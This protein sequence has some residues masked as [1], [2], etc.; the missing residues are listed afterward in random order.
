MRARLSAV[1]LA[2]G[3]TSALLLARCSI[4]SG[5]S[6]NCGMRVAGAMTFTRKLLCTAISAAARLPV[7]T[8]VCVLV[9]PSGVGA[10]G[11]AAAVTR[12]VGADADGLRFLA[13]TE[14]H[15]AR[16]DSGWRYVCPAL[17]GQDVPGDGLSPDGVQ[18]W[19]P[20]VGGLYQI[21][22][23]GRV[24][25]QGHPELDADTVV[26]VAVVAGSL[27]LHRFTPTGAQVVHLRDGEPEPVWSDERVW[28]A[29]V[30]HGQGLA[31]ARADGT[32][33]TVLLLDPDG[34]VAGT[35]THALGDDN[36][37]L[38]LRSAG[39]ALYV[40]TTAG[41]TN[42][43]HR[44]GD[45]E[46]VTVMDAE[47]AIMGPVQAGGALIA[48]SGNALV[49]LDDDTPTPLD[50]PQPVS[51]LT[52][53]GGAAY[54]CALHELYALDADGLGARLVTLADLQPPN[55][56]STECADQWT[57]FQADLVRT[58]P[59][60]DGDLAAD[61]VVDGDDDGGGSG[62]G[63]RIHRGQRHQSIPALAVLCALL[64]CICRRRPAR[65]GGRCTPGPGGAVA[66]PRPEA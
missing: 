8:L 19:L 49:R 7:A 46:L 10:H 2:A 59:G 65:R 56:P 57:L 14:G 37:S 26:G 64:A 16:D 60:F 22:H 44:V 41:S 3:P 62:G 5:T 32:S 34:S 45:A 39:G 1:A 25:S 23:A 24:T 11:S 48:A 13:L 30:A 9:V 29:M 12:V 27:Y 42:A 66:R 43:L 61:G 52:S 20:G 54:A 15:A 28:H 6:M 55:D 21:D 35:S 40:L 4:V 47:V 53:Y 63:C 58:V 31:L 38:R 17:Y 33:L 51:C 18:L 36:P 50:T